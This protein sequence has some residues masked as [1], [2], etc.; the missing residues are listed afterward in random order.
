[1]H[2][3]AWKEDELLDITLVRIGK[4]VAEKMRALALTS[5]CYMAKSKGALVLYGWGTCSQWKIHSLQVLR[6]ENQ[7]DTHTHTYIYI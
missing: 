7:R 3:H 5:V 1:M 6:H 4:A 2:G